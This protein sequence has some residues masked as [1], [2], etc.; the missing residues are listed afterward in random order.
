MLGCNIPWNRTRI[1]RWVNPFFLYRGAL[2]L[3]RTRN[4]FLAWLYLA[5]MSQYKPKMKGKMSQKFRELK[6]MGMS[7]NGV[8]ILL[9]S[10][11]HQ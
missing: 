3:T 5:G 6:G 4:T 8:F 7:S 9:D 10:Q 1:Q 2:T 11:R